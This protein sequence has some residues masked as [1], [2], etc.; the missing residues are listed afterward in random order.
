[1]RERWR[2]GIRIASAVAVLAG[3]KLAYDEYRTSEA[4][5]RADAPIVQALNTAKYALSSEPT[6]IYDFNGGGKVIATVPHAP[7]PLF[8]T[9][10]LERVRDEEVRQGRSMGAVENVLFQVSTAQTPA[11]FMS[12]QQAVSSLLDSLEHPGSPIKEPVG[13]IVG[14]AGIG[15]F[16]E[17]GRKR[18]SLP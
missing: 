11:D 4:K 13:I 2:K 8:A 5:D 18:Q 15:T 16:V 10:Q 9:H 12:A 14:G 1:M 6:K 7:D 17:V 3:G